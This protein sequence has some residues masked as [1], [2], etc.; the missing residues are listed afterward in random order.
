MLHTPVQ[1][2]QDVIQQ[3]GAEGLKVLGEDVTDGVKCVVAGGGHP[4][5]FLG[6]ERGAQRNQYVNMKSETVF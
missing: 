1:L 4:L 3:D 5:R 2:S 6:G